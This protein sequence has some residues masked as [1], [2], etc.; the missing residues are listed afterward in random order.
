MHTPPH[1]SSRGP[2]ALR[3]VMCALLR[4]CRPVALNGHPRAFDGEVVGLVPTFPQRSRPISCQGLVGGAQE[5][6]LCAVVPGPLPPKMP[7]RW[8]ALAGREFL[9]FFVLLF[10]LRLSFLTSSFP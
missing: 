3:G 1:E 2:S 8:V 4:P 9:E 10:F 6:D 7:G 5:A